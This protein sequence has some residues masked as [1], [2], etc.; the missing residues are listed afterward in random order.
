MGHAARRVRPHR[1][2]RLQWRRCPERLLRRHDR[3][4]L[5][6]ETAVNFLGPSADDAVGP[7]RACRGRQ[8]RA[9]RHH[10]G[11]GQGRG[12]RTCALRG[13]EGGV[14]AFLKTIVREYG[15]RGHPGELR[16]AGP[17]RHPDASVHAS[18]RDRGRRK[19]I[20][21]L[22]RLVPS[23]AS[24]APPRSRPPFGSSAPTASS[25]PGEHLSV[26]GGVT[27][28]VV[29][30]DAPPL[31]TQR[32]NHPWAARR[33]SSTST[34]CTGSRRNSRSWPTRS[35]RRSSSRPSATNCSPRTTCSASPSRGSTAARA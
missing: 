23:D 8:R 7:A 26:G 19:A 9:R 16:G 11:L 35:R 21:K 31:H 15:R 3:G 10:L 27:M 32:R 24:D 28:N 17:D 30:T 34:S 29:T 12:H 18:D 22:Q 6:R 33:R 5:V 14:D 25:S 20:A 13:D 2:H 1:R 4:R